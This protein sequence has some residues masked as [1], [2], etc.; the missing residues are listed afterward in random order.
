MSSAEPE[1]I[2]ARPPL[3]TAILAQRGLYDAK[4][5]DLMQKFHINMREDFVFGPIFADRGADWNAH[6][7]RMVLDRSDVR[8]II[9]AHAS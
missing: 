9:T 8:S 2:P 5:T 3:T 4:L 6:L 1:T 7:S